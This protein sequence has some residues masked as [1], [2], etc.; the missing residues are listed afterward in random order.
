MKSI[1]DNIGNFFESLNPVDVLYRIFSMQDIKDRLIASVQARLEFEG[2]TASGL[3][4]KTDRAIE[5]DQGLVY[6]GFNEKAENKFVDLLDTRDFYL[7][8]NV[9]S[10]ANNILIDADFEKKDGNIFDNFQHSFSSQKDFEK[11][12][13]TPIIDEYF[14]DFVDYDLMPVFYDEIEKIIQGFI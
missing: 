8:F 11:E 4:L 12:I 10:K 9:E 14:T 7:S 5:Q 6:S 3:K 1:F 13:L 2:I